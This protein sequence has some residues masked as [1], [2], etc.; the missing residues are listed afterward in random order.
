MATSSA[1]SPEFDS[2]MTTSSGVIMPKSPWLASAG[3]IEKVG[4]PVLAM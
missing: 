4:V 1:L 2:A 3:C